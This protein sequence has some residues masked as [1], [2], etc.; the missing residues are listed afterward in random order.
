MQIDLKRLTV[1]HINILED[2]CTGLRKEEKNICFPKKNVGTLRNYF[3]I[4]Y[5]FLPFFS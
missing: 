4:F 2:A 5:C 1:F 3:F